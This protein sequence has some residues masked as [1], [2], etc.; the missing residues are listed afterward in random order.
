M[1]DGTRRHGFLDIPALRM[2]YSFGAFAMQP[3]GD[4]SVVPG[5]P[6]PFGV[7]RTIS[8]GDQAPSPIR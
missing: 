2:P 7:S 4:A 8:E 3:L 5:I 1:G 6:Y